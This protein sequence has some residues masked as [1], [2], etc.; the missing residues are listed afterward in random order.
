MIP[1]L[2]RGTPN[3]QFTVAPALVAAVILVA[4]C[5]SSDHFRE[6]GYH[7]TAGLGLSL[8]GYIVL[9]SIDATEHKGVAYMAI[10][11]MTAGVRTAATVQSTI[12]Y[13]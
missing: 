11:F 4:L 1:M 5:L 6:R 13:N 10:F 9:A 2:T 7:I 8:I 12:F 3:T